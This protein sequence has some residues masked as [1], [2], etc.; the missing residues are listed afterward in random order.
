MAEVPVPSAQR[1]A[2][3]QAPVPASESRAP[4]QGVRRCT[5]QKEESTRYNKPEAALRATPVMLPK[6]C[7]SVDAVK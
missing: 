4:L 6:P 7:E 3:E 2:G 5:R 1:C